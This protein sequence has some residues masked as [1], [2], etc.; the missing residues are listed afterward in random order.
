MRVIKSYRYH[1]VMN[2]D[3]DKDLNDH[4]LLYRISPESI[5]NISLIPWPSDLGY[6]VCIFYRSDEE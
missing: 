4:L 3:F 5:I 6:M 2:D 1:T